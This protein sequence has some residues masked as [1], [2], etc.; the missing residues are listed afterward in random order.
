MDTV[1]IENFI[2]VP[3]T[4]GP[5]LAASLEQHVKQYGVEVITEQ[6]AAAISRMATSTWIRLWRHLEEPRRDP[7]DRCRWRDL[8]VPG[9]LEYRTKGVAYCPHCDG[10]SSRASGSR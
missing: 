6:R 3:Y 2:S 4:E 10:P 1:G 8:N 5:K 9:E 7:G